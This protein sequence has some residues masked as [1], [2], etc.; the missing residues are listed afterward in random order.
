MQQAG[1]NAQTL[2]PIDNM[3]TKNFVVKKLIDVTRNK[4]RIRTGVSHFI[5]MDG[6]REASGGG[7]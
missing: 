4:K 6:W 2:L 1:K 5:Y 7:A 3:D